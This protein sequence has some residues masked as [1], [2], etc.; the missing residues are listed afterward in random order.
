MKRTPTEIMTLSPSKCYCPPQVFGPCVSPQSNEVASPRFPLISSRTF[1]RL[2]YSSAPPS[3]DR[4]RL[5][6]T[7]VSPSYSHHKP[8]ERIFSAHPAIGPCY[9]VP[10]S[11][12]LGRCFGGDGGKNKVEPGTKPSF[13]SHV[14]GIPNLQ[15]CRDVR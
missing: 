7:E 9:A 6:R 10:A 8:L 12:P 13:T 2:T 14:S 3:L 4:T 5:R 15:R 11:D 1:A